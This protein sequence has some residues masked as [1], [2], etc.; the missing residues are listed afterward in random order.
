MQQCLRTTRWFGVLLAITMLSA[1]LQLVTAATLDS[2]STR[3][4]NKVH[5]A[6][7]D[8]TTPRILV[9]LYIY[10]LPNAW[11]PLYTAIRSN[12]SAAFTVI[13]NPNSGPGSG[14]APDADYAAAIK[15][16]RSTAGPGQILEL[17]GYVPTGYGKRSATKVK[18][19]VSTY[20][21]WPTALRPDGIF[22]DE[23]STQSRFLAKYR[24]YTDLVKSTRW[25]TAARKGITVLNPGTWPQ[26]A[27]FFTLAADHIVVY[28]DTLAKFNFSDYQRRTAKNHLG[29]AFQRS[30]IFYNVDASNVR[31]ADGKVFAGIEGLVVDATVN[32]LSSR[33]GLFVTNLDIASTDVYAKFSSI[34]QQLVQAVARVSR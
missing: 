14:T 5:A 28:E 34:W 11:D 25:S 30:Y 24:T 33:G 32:G 19:D 13:I 26:D 10:P 29:S 16:L 8:T 1:F 3:K 31:T 17:V 23:T 4:S 21:H 18:A 27:R 2:C 12:P 20:A 22:F 7:A 15:T 6:K 9:P